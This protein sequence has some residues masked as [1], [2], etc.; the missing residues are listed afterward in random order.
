MSYRWIKLSA[1]AQAAAKWQAERGLDGSIGT[2]LPELLST[3]ACEEMN[4][5]PV[6]F[7]LAVHMNRL[8]HLS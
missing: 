3:R 7:K 2:A 1:E 5:N 8:T 6:L 4:A